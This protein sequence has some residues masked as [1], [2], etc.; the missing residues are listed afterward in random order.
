MRIEDLNVGDKVNVVSLDVS[1]SEFGLDDEGDMLAAFKDGGEYTIEEVD[2]SDASVRLMHSSF[3]DED[4]LGWW[5]DIRDL[6]VAA[7]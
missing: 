5:Y 7:E 1:K 6:E 3:T 2:G 4:E